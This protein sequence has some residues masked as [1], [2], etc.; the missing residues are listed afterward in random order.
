VRRGVYRN[1]AV[2]S[3][4]LVAAVLPWTAALLA[5]YR[6]NYADPG[7]QV[8]PPE[9]VDYV[10]E[11]SRM[12]ERLP[13]LEE[14][15]EFARRFYRECEVRVDMALLL[16]YGVERPVNY[17]GRWY[18][19]FFAVVYDP[20]TGRILHAFLNRSSLLPVVS[21]SNDYT[22]N[23]FLRGLQPIGYQMWLVE[24]DAEAFTRGSL[25]IV[26]WYYRW[27]ETHLLNPYT[28]YNS[29]PLR[30]YCP[31]PEGFDYSLYFRGLPETVT[32]TQTHT[33]TETYTP[34]PVTLTRTVTAT[35]TLPPATVTLTETA[36]AYYTA[37]ETLTLPPI[38]VT[39]VLTL[40]P[41]TSTTTLTETA[42]EVVTVTET[43]AVVETSFR[44]V[45]P[46]T[47][48]LAPVA[49]PPRVD[50]SAVA[51]AVAFAIGLGVGLLLRRTAR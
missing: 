46:V 41:E 11:L 12:P 38:T 32:V 43:V 8:L 2:L 15:R 21:W 27:N 50:A 31:L 40:P 33:V 42:T 37:T 24:V 9:V 19:P 14:Y 26:A 3:I 49:T 4:L 29:R 17:S 39:E 1:P 25:V 5:E 22:M 10:L 13:S 6:P 23:P 7:G 47:V 20:L 34:P 18:W 16:L 51:G 35:T 48:T 36:T 44:T 30:P 28:L 45:P